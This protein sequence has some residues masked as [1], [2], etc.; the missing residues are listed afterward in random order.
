MKTILIAAALTLAG[1]A[2]AMDDHGMQKGMQG[3]MS[4]GAMS[5]MEKPR[6]AMPMRAASGALADGEVRKVDREAGKITLRHGPLPSMGIPAMTMVY[7]V[8]D[9]SALEHFSAGDKV[10]YAAEKTDSGY[11]ITRIERAH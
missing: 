11:T 6:D 3:G 7:D 4:G 10:K 8:K 9:A 5:G 1:N 2:F